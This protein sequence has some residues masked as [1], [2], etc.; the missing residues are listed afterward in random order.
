MDP[1]HQDPTWAEK[2]GLPVS[3]VRAMRLAA[4]ISDSSRNARIGK[5]DTTSLRQRNQILVVEGL[6]GS[7][8]V[9][10]RQAEGFREV[11]SLT[12][13]PTLPGWT[14]TSRA[15]NSEQPT[16]MMGAKVSV[17]TDMRIVVE[18]PVRLDPFE[19]S[20]PM[21]RFAFAWDGSQYKLVDE[22]R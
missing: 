2:T 3:E 6:C 5:I 17:T 10:E 16:C 18:V 22:A 12:K 15:V 13:L 19:R 8:H 14:S 11:W 7:L 4:G 9:L 1:A 20:V 21:S